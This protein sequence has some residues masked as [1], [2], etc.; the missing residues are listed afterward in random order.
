MCINI[1]THVH[2]EANKIFKTMIISHFVFPHLNTMTGLGKYVYVRPYET[3]HSHSKS[4][5]HVTDG[6]SRAVIQHTLCFI[7]MLL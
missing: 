3:N 7:F 5:Q 1:I 4:R 2:T 6:D